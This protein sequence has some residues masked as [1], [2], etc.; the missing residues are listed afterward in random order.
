M[1]VTICVPVYGVEKY[2]ERCAISLFEQTY[3]DIEFIFVDDCSTDKSISILHEVI[4][5]YQY[6]KNDIKI[7]KHDQNRGLAAAR[8]TGVSAAFGEFILHVDSDD[9]IEQT[10]IEKLVASQN[11]SNADIV[12]FDAISYYPKY[13]ERITHPDYKSP[14]DMCLMLLSSRGAPPYVWCRFI[15]KSLYID[16]HIKAYEGYNMG[17]DAQVTPVLAYYAKKITV[18]HQL[19]YHYE[20]RNLKSYTKSFS[21][22]KYMQTIGSRKVLYDFFKDKGDVFEDALKESET[23]NLISLI[24]NTSKLKDLSRC[25]LFISEKGKI[26]K[27]YYKYIRLPKRIVAYIDNPYIIKVYVLCLGYLKHLFQRIIN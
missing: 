5:R 11:Q 22:D 20:C 8:N 19:L 15:R 21:E 4:N 1:R 9:W 12:A 2:I 18:L 6:R 24:I 25:R 23:K 16:N 13:K 17:E 7:I 26:H 14:L 27:K 3:Q 10:A